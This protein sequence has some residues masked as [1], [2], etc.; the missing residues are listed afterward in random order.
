MNSDKMTAIYFTFPDKRLT[1][2]CQGC[3]AC[4]KGLG[5]G[6]D[7]HKEMVDL[8]HT[9][10]MLSFFS[11]ARGD[12]WTVFNPRSRCWF[13]GDDGLCSLEKEF[14]R[15]MKPASCRLFPF[16][17]VFRMGTWLIVDYNAVLCPLNT[18]TEGVSHSSILEEISTITDPAIIGSKID[19]RGDDWIEKEMKIAEVA[20]S[21]NISWYDCL[22]VQA[23]H[24]N[25]DKDQVVFEMRNAFDE[26]FHQR[27]NLY[28]SETIKNAIIA[29]PSI[30]FN[31]EFGP[32]R[33]FRDKHWDRDLCAMWLGWLFLCQMGEEL[34]GKSLSIQDVTSIW[35]DSIT[36]LFCLAHWYH[37]PNLDPQTVSFTCPTEDRA[38]LVAFARSCICNTK[39][40]LNHLAKPLIGEVQIF[41]AQARLRMLEP[42]FLRMRFFR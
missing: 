11:R 5:I 7:S 26:V 15:H 39:Y 19:K 32:R 8:L 33:W 22:A 28:L 13:L 38:S 25:S 42:L 1:Y 10:P 35:I 29:T 14:G 31:E 40:T 2:N 18:S 20:F 21:P 24:A 17:R 6:L 30:R 4:C 41:R 9:F 16:N 34:K 23:Y 37:R 27:P 36:L 3:L 12:A